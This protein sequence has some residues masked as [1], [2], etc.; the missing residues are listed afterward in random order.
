ML[1]R[2]VPNVGHQTT[3]HTNNINST[4][5]MQVWK[6]A[7]L[8]VMPFVQSRHLQLLA[9]TCKELTTKWIGPGDLLGFAVFIDDSR[10]ATNVLALRFQ[11]ILVDHEVPLAH[12]LFLPVSKYPSHS[13]SNTN[14]VSITFTTLKDSECITG[15]TKMSYIRHYNTAT[16]SVIL[17]V[18]I[19]QMK[20]SSTPAIGSAVRLMRFTC[21][22]PDTLVPLVHQGPSL[23]LPFQN[24]SQAAPFC[25][26]STLTSVIVVI[27]EG[28]QPATCNQ[29]YHPIN[30]KQSL[31]GSDA[32]VGN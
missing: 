11:L 12:G 28:D 30:L 6:V 31:P 22:C 25:G 4:R 7:S 16:T 19:V 14:H 32:W 21:P 8:E 20:L 5:F 17:A 29:N 24:V 23:K 9:R 27:L 15:E 1:A 3:L 13:S 10:V 2:L 18:I 26:I